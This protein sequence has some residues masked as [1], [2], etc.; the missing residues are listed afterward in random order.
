MKIVKLTCLSILLLGGA[1]HSMDQTP[2]LIKLGKQLAKAASQ[3]DLPMVEQLIAQKADLNLRALNGAT[4]L[5]SAT[6]NGRS[7]I[8]QMLINAHADLYQKDNNGYTALMFAAESGRSDIARMLINAHANPNQKNYR[9]ET[10]M[11]MAAKYNHPQMLI[12]AQ[13]LIDAM[14]AHQQNF[15][16]REQINGIEDPDMKVQLLEYFESKI[17]SENEQKK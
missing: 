13:M 1:L 10:A 12:V 15:I 8:V 7:K 5:M 14:L 16:I 9:G 2:D 4:A 3:G 17:K 6:L 11:L